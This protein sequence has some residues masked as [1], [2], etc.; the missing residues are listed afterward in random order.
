MGD[1]EIWDGERSVSS[2]FFLD[3]CI[4]L[5][6]RRLDH[7]RH[8]GCPP[9]EL[10]DHGSL[11][12]PQRCSHWFQILYAPP[13]QILLLHDRV[14]EKTLFHGRD[15]LLDLVGRLT[16]VGRFLQQAFWPFPYHLSI[17][18]ELL[19]QSH[20]FPPSLDHDCSSNLD[21]EPLYFLITDIPST[22]LLYQHC[23][24]ELPFILQP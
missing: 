24:I 22:V 15:L 20:T 7:L 17:A 4:V 5:L 14:A 19:P 6:C 18:T 21:P 9:F 2:S 8:L 16:W 23:G 11:S 3:G 10:L 1:E 12:L 13:Y